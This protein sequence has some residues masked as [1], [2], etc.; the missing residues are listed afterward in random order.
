MDDEFK[1]KKKQYIEALDARLKHDL[2]DEE[3]WIVQEFLK[4]H[5][6]NFNEEDIIKEPQNSKIDISFKDCCFQIKKILYPKDYKIKDEDRKNMNHIT[7]AMNRDELVNVTVIKSGFE[8]EYLKPEYLSGEIIQK[9]FEWT[10]RKR[11]DV[12][13]YPP[14]TREKLDLLF[15]IE[16]D[17][18]NAKHRPQGIIYDK[19]IS[20][21]LKEAGW[22]SISYLYGSLSLILYVS[23]NTPDILKSIYSQQIKATHK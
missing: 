8:G 13:R 6:I 12:L 21:Q 22:R 18:A 2:S 7:N 15:Y 14:E 10:T 9:S 3:I 4:K 17:L 19:I 1:S 23:E 16:V 5:N 20:E 11:K